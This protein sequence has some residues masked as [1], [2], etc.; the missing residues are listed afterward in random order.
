MKVC[1][2]SRCLLVVGSLLFFGANALAQSQPIS[3]MDNPLIAE[4]LSTNPPPPGFGT[5]WDYIKS[6]TNETDIE[7]AYRTGKISKG[8]AMLAATINKISPNDKSP[9]DTY[10]KVIDQNGLPV[11][12]AKIRGYLE[13]EEMGI[14]EEHVTETDGQGRFQFL[15]LHAKDLVAVPV[16]E[17][18]EFDLRQPVYR[19]KN[20]LP[21]RDNPLVF[22]MWKLRGPEPMT[23]ADIESSISRDGTTRT[24]SLLTG[25]RDISGSLAVQLLREPLEIAAK[26]LRKP[27]NWS[28]T[29][30]ITNGGLFG[31][32]NQ[33]YPYEAPSEGYQA[34]ITIKYTTNTVGWQSWF[35]HDYYYKSQKGQI[36][37]RM[38]VEV[39]AGAPTPEAYFKVDTYANPGGSRNLEFDA[40]KQIQK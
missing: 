13:F 35:K 32:T 17:G 29:L 39:H 33:P 15:G 27:F 10:G 28:L 21:D 34:V 2:F 20:Y 19:P 14:K 40:G 25:K 7:K 16:K 26:D 18:Y 31:Y 12:G 37:G 24:F 5:R 11:V 23:H 3:P 9:V 38:T 36:Y 4:I 8:E 30:A 6:F 22:T 1:N